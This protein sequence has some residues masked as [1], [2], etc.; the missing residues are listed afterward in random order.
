M[1]FL[2]DH[3]IPPGG[4]QYRQ[5]Q[6]GWVAPFPVNNTLDQQTTNLIKHRLANPAIVAK[7][8][9][10]TDRAAVKREIKM[11]NSL[12]LGIPM[13]ATAAPKSEPRPALGQLAA[14]LVAATKRVAAGVALLL[15]WEE[16]GLPPVGPDISHARADVCARCP[17]NSS[18]PLTD[19]FTVPMADLIRRR[20][21]RLHELNLS[22]PRDAQLGTCEA[23]Y[24][25]MRLKVHTP[26]SLVR[27][28]TKEEVRKDLWPQCWILAEEKNPPP[29]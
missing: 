16:S 13:E 11:F 12:R 10:S 3:S 4:W 15:E 27:K 1:Q 25:P 24:C 22:T 20:L 9:L 19:F 8:N 17:K 18:K 23:C 28:H 6:T 7:H 2:D 29:E 5:P 26:S 14:G 21:Q